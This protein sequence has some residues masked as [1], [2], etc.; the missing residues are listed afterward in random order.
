MSEYSIINLLNYNSQ[1]NREAVIMGGPSN[2]LKQTFIFFRLNYFDFLTLP[3]AVS[4][5]VLVPE[6]PHQD[7]AV[8]DNCATRH[9]GQELSLR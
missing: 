7:F 3:S 1:L 8:D 6:R 4:R 2:G 5:N 9:R